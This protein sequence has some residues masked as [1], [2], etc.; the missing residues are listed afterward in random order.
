MSAGVD[1]SKALGTKL[2]DTD[3]KD[4]LNTIDPKP[5]WTRDEGLLHWVSRSAGLDLQG[6]IERNELMTI[7]FFNEGVSKHAVCSVP[8]PEGLS[9]H[10]SRDAVI[11]HLG[12]SDKSGPKHDCWNRAGHRLI[13]QYDPTGQITKVT[14]TKM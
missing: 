3:L 9:I 1:L 13:A 12:P 4:A 8:L 14:I 10:W 11:Q 7:F 2:D 5:K 6:N